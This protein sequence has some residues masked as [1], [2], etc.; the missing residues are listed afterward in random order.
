MLVD[1]VVGTQPLIVARLLWNLPDLSRTRCAHN[2][3]QVLFQLWVV[4]IHSEP[5][6]RYVP[7]AALQDFTYSGSIERGRVDELDGVSNHGSFHT[8]IERV[9]TRHGWGYIDFN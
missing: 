4:F 8:V 3:L 2:V 1:L 5:V 9:I 7:K 6:F